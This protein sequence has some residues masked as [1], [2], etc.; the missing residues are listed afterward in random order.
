MGKV[1][2]CNCHH[3]YQDDIYGEGMR[4]ANLAAKSGGYRCTVCSELHKMNVEAAPKK[5]DK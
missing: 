5:K 4:Y 1:I 3:V 2:K